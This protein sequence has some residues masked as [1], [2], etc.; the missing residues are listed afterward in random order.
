MLVIEKLPGANT[1]EVT[2]GVEDALDA[3]RPGLSGVRIDT[4]VYRPATFIE[5]AVANLR[6]LLLLGLLLVGLLLVAFL[7]NWRIG[8]ISCRRHPAV[9]AG[10]RAGAEPAG[11]HLQRPHPDR[12]R[13]S[14][15]R[16]GR[17]CRRRRGT[18]TPAAAR[19]SRGRG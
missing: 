3:M 12:A 2:K 7:L 10:G 17:R 5:Q 9:S 15:R 16:R 8:V 14:R 13:H 11:R 6:T 18:H 19:A 4:T 1:L